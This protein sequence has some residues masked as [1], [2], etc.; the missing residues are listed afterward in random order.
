MTVCLVV[1]N[2]TSGGFY[3]SNKSL[4]VLGS[5]D[6]NTLVHEIFHAASIHNYKKGFVD[7]LS[8]TTQEKMAYDAEN[9]LMQIRAFQEDLNI[10]PDI[11]NEKKQKLDLP[12]KPVYAVNFATTSKR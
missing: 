4:M 8:G 11:S 2:G 5:F 9:L 10:T 6:E 1:F 3:D 12:L 7:M